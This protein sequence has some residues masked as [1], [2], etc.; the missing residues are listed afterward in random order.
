MV[1][2]NVQ[3]VILGT[4][5]DWHIRVCN[6]LISLGLASTQLQVYRIQS[7]IVVHRD[8]I[9]TPTHYVSSVVEMKCTIAISI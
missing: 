3:F 2:I 8:I 6:R 5:V 7:S 1:T 9:S 4:N